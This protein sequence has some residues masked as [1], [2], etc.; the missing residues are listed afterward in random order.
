MN[1]VLVI[2]VIVSGII[3]LYFSYRYHRS[4]R[5]EVLNLENEVSLNDVGISKMS[6]MKVDKTTKI[7]GYDLTRDIQLTKSD[8]GLDQVDNS[9][10]LNKP[11]SKLT[12][13][14]KTDK[15]TSICSAN[16]YLRADQASAAK[17]AIDSFYNSRGDEN[18]PAKYKSGNVFYRRIETVDGNWETPL[19]L[20]LVSDYPIYSHFYFECNSG[21]SFDVS[22][23]RSD[24]ESKYSSISVN[25]GYMAV[26]VSTGDVWAYMGQLKCNV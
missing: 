13:L 23:R 25:N 4:F 1:R 24:Q 17:A 6:E 26:F 12:D 20:P 16:L 3:V 14:I 2:S 19:Y 22:T 18:T 11:I 7:N 15:L 21:M 8:I 10:D 5:A 9:S